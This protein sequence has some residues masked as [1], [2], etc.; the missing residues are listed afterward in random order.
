L[1]VSS[2]S[3]WLKVDYNSFR[4]YGNPTI[5]DIE[6]T[7]LGFYTNFNVTISATDPSGASTIS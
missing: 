7:S 3:F 4:I 5:N 2:G 6:R 1:I